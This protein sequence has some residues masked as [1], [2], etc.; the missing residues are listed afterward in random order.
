MSEISKFERELGV[1]LSGGHRGR[2]AVGRDDLV[3][4]LA[5]HGREVAKRVFVVF[6]E[7]DSRDRARLAA[8]GGAA[9]A[10]ARLTWKPWCWLAGERPSVRAGK[11]SHA[12]ARGSK[13]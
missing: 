5:K 6:D 11:S 10:S 12:R 8:T 13:P 2:D 4:A 9:G 1:S 7:Q 3:A